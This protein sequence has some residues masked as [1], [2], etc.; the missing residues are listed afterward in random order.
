MQHTL[1]LA[2]KH[3]ALPSSESGHCCGRA[4]YSM[5][6]HPETPALPSLSAKPFSSMLP[7]ES[8]QG[9]IEGWTAGVNIMHAF[10]GNGIESVEPFAVRKRHRGMRSN[11]GAYLELPIMQAVARRICSQCVIVTCQG[12]LRPQ[13]CL[14][15]DDSIPV[16]TGLVNPDKISAGECLRIRKSTPWAAGCDLLKIFQIQCLHVVRKLYWNS[17]MQSMGDHHCHWYGTLKLTCICPDN[18]GLTKACCPFF[19]PK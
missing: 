4:A 14:P 2:M 13:V 5:S 6:S 7:C 8:Q 17:D 12:V 19:E 11:D 3:T 18:A 16:W 10:W 9:C 15:P 1:G